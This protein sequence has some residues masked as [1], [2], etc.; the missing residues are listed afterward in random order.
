MPHNSNNSRTHSHSNELEHRV[1]HTEA[2]LERLREIHDE[3]RED[4][5]RTSAQ[6]SEKLTLHEKAILAIA[7]V[8]YIMAQD[9]FPA[10]AAIIK[11]F[12]Q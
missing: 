6:H 5:E 9:K 11:G 2:S 12:R 8:L 4:H 7:G 3:L 10:I 1:T